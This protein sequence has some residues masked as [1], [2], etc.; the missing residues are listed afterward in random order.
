MS[1][2]FLGGFA[3]LFAGIVL[4]S[5]QQGK[6]PSLPHDLRNALHDAQAAVEGD[7][8]YQMESVWQGQLDGDSFFHAA[9][10]LATLS[11][12]TY[13]YEVAEQRYR[14]IIARA[15]YMASSEQSGRSREEI[16]LRAANI[17]AH[18]YLGLAWQ[19]DTRGML[20]D[21]DTLFL[22]ARL[23]ARLSNDQ[24][25]EAEAMLGRAL[26]RGPVD[27]AVVAR[28]VVDSALSYLTGRDTELHSEYWMRRAVLSAV[29]SDPAAGEEASRARKIAHQ[30][31][32]LRRE[33]KA[34]RVLA[35]DQSLRG[36]HSNAI[37]LYDTAALLQ[38]QAKDWSSL[39]ETLL[40][41][42]DALRSRGD[43]AGFKSTMIEAAKEA[44]RSHNR[45]ASRSVLLQLGALALLVKDYISADA[46]LDQAIERATADNAIADLMLARSYRANLYL[47][48][49][50]I[51]KARVETHIVAEYHR[52]TGDGAYEL[53]ALR[54][55]IALELR[56]GNLTAA[57][58]ALTNAQRLARSRN[59]NIWLKWLDEE[60][61]MVEAAK[62]NHDNA[63]QLLR[64]VLVSLDST[65]HIDRH[66]VRVKL[67]EIY[68]ELGNPDA[69][70][71]ELRQAENELEQWRSSLNDRDLRLLAVQVASRH[72]GAGNRSL[73]VTLAA[74]A[75]GGRAKEALQIIER[76]RGRELVDRIMQA[77]ALAPA[78]NTSESFGTGMRAL[79]PR[80]NLEQISSLSDS[81]SAVL[82]FITGV[83]DAPTTMFL[84]QKREDNSR[85]I[86]TFNLP[87]A[88]S[89]TP[90]IVR[91]VALI[92]AGE[93]PQHLGRLLGET[94]L[95][96]V[97]AE[98]YM[99]SDSHDTIVRKLI[100]I[101]DGPLNSLP[102]DVLRLEDGRFAVEQFNFTFAPS[103]SAIL[104]LRDRS[105][106]N[107]RTRQEASVLAFGDPVFNRGPVDSSLSPDL[108]DA[109]SSL[110]RLA[111]S[112]DEARRVA[113]YG[114][115]SQVRLRD[116][117]SIKALR[118]TV[119]SDFNILHFATHALVDERSAARTMLVLSSTDDDSGLVSPG[120]LTSL[121]LNAD[122]VVLS[123]C[124]TAGG[125]V[126]DGEGTQGLTS[127]FLEAG[128]RSVVASQ[129][130]IGDKSTVRMVDALYNGISQGL[131]VSDALRE[132]KLAAL[133]DG[134]PQ[135]DWAAFT[136]VGDPDVKIRLASIAPS[137]GK[138]GILI[139]LGLT[140]IAA[141]VVWYTRRKARI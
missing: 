13:N 88:D 125:V 123:A 69:A 29:L 37:A 73:A 108:I 7:S 96:P 80:I 87:S 5:V 38:R 140:A 110:P 103:S 10:G 77:K 64:S 43:F 124:R 66:M 67:A 89:L 34:I 20:S 44:S 31:N 22:R 58:Q 46:Y 83:G 90:L 102:F 131:S 42:G 82:A 141:L 132:S 135:R 52:R 48:V 116:K 101:P 60:K 107:R 139:F 115:E 85:N 112:G 17:I 122:L 99:G 36:N 12:L 127:A 94:I 19:A 91:L 72:E 113:R 92:E 76:R 119:L 137:R 24:L 15:E 53:N 32:D 136:V 33:A 70:V 54:D 111:A 100:I 25:A 118:E 130:R 78:T 39:A 63:A 61:A 105:L 86:Q 16:R 21:A 129:W 27:G 41:K 133:R 120:E 35:L 56:A 81:S 62:G 121:K 40:R 50:D 117:A 28:D 75:N 93:D 6:I 47:A 68:T 126:I 2:R 74:L 114:S 128:A 98:L 4:M 51:D 57:Q 14:E 97:M 49:G 9:F 23:N 3:S 26:A 95:D 104:A 84:V 59:E 71:I 30:R 11:R 1:V 79:L 109:A 65:Q 45:I 18:A 55:L 106:S 134:V 138:T 8:V